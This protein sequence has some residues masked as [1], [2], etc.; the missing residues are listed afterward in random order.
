MSQPDNPLE[1]AV[2]RAMAAFVYA[3]IGLLFEGPEPFP[4]LVRK[5]RSQMRQAK[6]VGRFAVER[7]QGKACRLLAQ[8][9]DEF[10][11][12]LGHL[13][14]SAADS[15]PR[16]APRS[17]PTK[18]P[19]SAAKPKPR[20]APTPKPD[21]AIPDYDSLSASQVVTRLAGLSKDELE[22]VRTHE[23]A[24]RGRKTILNKVAQLQ[25]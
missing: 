11:E 17:A 3:P 1:D 20:P 13:G 14:S 15:S 25:A 4:E 22:S 21:L 2:A 6:V 7:G 18:R 9:R 5:G 24:N 19:A 16:P 12:S 23:A 10:I 8:R